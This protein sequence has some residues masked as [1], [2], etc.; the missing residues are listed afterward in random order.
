MCELADFAPFASA[1]LVL[2]GDA[3]DGGDAKFPAWRIAAT[4]S[5]SLWV[6]MRK[7]IA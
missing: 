4:Q 7:M 5:I 1:S 6:R 2:G 3:K